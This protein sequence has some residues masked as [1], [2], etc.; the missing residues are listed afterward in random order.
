ML[1]GDWTLYEYGGAV[2]ISSAGLWG[3][4]QKVFKEHKG[5]KFEYA[6]GVPKGEGELDGIYI[7]DNAKTDNWTLEK[8]G[9]LKDNQT[10][11]SGKGYGGYQGY[12]YEPYEPATALKPII[13]PSGTPKTEVTEKPFIV[14][15]PLNLPMPAQD[16]EVVGYDL[17][18]N[19]I[20]LVDNELHIVTGGCCIAGKCAE[21]WDYLDRETADSLIRSGVVCNRRNP[22]MY[23]E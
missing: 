6:E 16:N 3:L 11:Y 10:Y 21:L 9:T 17:G 12:H 14:Q 20:I 8:L 22:L 18:G 5:V 7:M 15:L 1:F 19:D 13:L 2:V 23:W 4:G